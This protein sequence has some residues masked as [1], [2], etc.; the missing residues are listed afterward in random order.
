MEIG[1][2]LGYIGTA[3][4]GGVV[5]QIANWRLNKNKVKEEVKSDEIDN[6]RKSVEVYQTIISDCTNRLADQNVRIGELTEE[7][8]SLREQLRTERNEHERQIQALQKQIV[9]ITKVLGMKNSQKI[10]DTKKAEK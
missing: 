9:E 1:E 6:I 8:N 7:V 3:F 10:K 5:T 2:I 4:G